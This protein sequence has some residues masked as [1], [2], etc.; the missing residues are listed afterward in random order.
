MAIVHHYNQAWQDQFRAV[1]EIKSG[2]AMITAIHPHHGVETIYLSAEKWQDNI[3][4]VLT[5]Y[6][7]NGY[8]V[9]MIPM[10]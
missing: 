7:I 1:P 3:G 6:W 5:P 2:Y 9:T 8:T 4:S 10:D